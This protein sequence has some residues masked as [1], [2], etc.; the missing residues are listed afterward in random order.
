MRNAMKTKFYNFSLKSAK[1]MLLLACFQNILTQQFDSI[2]DIRDS[3][4]YKVV[5]IGN[6]W[7]MAQNLNYFTSNGSKYYKD[8]SIKYAALYGRLYQ[9]PTANKSC[10]VD[11]VR[12]FF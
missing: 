10:P 4:K 6:Q 5:K 9:W 12:A 8:D 7:W 2:T 3:Q 1:L 11:W